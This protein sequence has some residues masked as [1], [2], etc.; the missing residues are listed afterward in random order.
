MQMMIDAIRTEH[1]A[2]AESF[3]PAELE[4]HIAQFVIRLELLSE[5]PAIRQKARQRWVEEERA[6]KRLTSNK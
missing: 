2:L 3:K 1:P 5:L 4:D 6:T